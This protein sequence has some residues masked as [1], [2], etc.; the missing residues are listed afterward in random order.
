MGAA[1]EAFDSDAY[2]MHTAVYP[3]SCC[4]CGFLRHDKKTACRERLPPHR[5]LAVAAATT[6][7]GYGFLAPNGAQNPFLCVP[8]RDNHRPSSR[9]P[10]SLQPCRHTSLFT[11]PCTLGTIQSIASRFHATLLFCRCLIP[12]MQ[13]PER[14]SMPQLIGYVPDFSTSATTRARS[15][16]PLL[17]IHTICCRVSLFPSSD[18]CMLS[19]IASSPNRGMTLGSAP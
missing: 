7:N 16:K 12:C 13:S 10:L 14:V 9:S 5:K 17:L 6:K 19:S 3:T 2:R 4:F 15:R 18:I 8:T 11:V 1:N